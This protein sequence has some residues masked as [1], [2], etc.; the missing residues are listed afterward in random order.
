M[1]SLAA[2]AAQSTCPPG[3][4]GHLP[5]D[6]QVTHISVDQTIV[7]TVGPERTE[8]Y[9]SRELD[10]R[11][12]TSA[13]RVQ[14]AGDAPMIPQQAVQLGIALIAEGFEAL[15]WSAQAPTCTAE[16]DDLTTRPEAARGS[17]RG[18]HHD[19]CPWASVLWMAELVRRVTR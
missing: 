1:N 13:V 3:C 8:I 11:T 17:A 2:H 9:V 12:G 10:E 6:D 15:R 14:G 18:W 7:A 5:S 19:D 4:E 16:C